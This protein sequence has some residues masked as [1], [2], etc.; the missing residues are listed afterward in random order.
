[1]ERS[2]VRLKKHLLVKGVKTQRQKKFFM[3]FFLLNLFTLPIRLF[4]PTSRIP[5][6]KLFR[7]LESLWKSNEKSGL[8]FVKFCS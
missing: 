4:A 8:R 2:G 5:L 6:S 1:M 7:F 3:D